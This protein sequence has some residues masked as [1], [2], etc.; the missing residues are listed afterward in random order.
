MLLV[1]AVVQWVHV[2]VLVVV[3]V[4]HPRARLRR[5]ERVACV[6]TQERQ[7]VGPAADSDRHQTAAGD[8]GAPEEPAAPESGDRTVAATAVPWVQRARGSPP[9]RP[10]GRDA[11]AGLLPAVRALAAPVILC[12][13]PPRLGRASA[14]AGA[15]RAGRTRNSGSGATPKRRVRPNGSPSRHVRGSVFGSR[16]RICACSRRGNSVCDHPRRATDALLRENGG[17]FHSRRRRTRSSPPPLA[18]RL[19]RRDSTELSRRKPP[20]RLRP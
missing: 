3:V 19:L 5:P 9:R 6:A 10:H 13:G 18:S 15:A 1:V 12:H 14:D 16:V 7:R 17:P 11:S 8:A 20:R 2:H 4:L